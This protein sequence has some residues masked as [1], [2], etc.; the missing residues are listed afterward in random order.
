MVHSTVMK[1]VGYLDEHSAMTKDS[2]RVLM[3]GIHSEPLKA[4][5]LDPKKGPHLV[6][7]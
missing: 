6:S 4:E 1:L 2:W 7:S 3:W 5:L